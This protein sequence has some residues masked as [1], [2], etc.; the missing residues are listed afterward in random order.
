MFVLILTF[1]LALPVRAQEITP[2]VVDSTIPVDA[3][4]R[5]AVD[6]W[7]ATSAPVPYPYY[8][9]T[10]VDPNIDTFVSLVAVDIANPTDAWNATEDNTVVWRGSVIVRA[11]NS[12]ELFLP[13][14]PAEIG[15]T[16]RLAI[17]KFPLPKPDAGGGSY[18]SFPW[19]AGKAMMYGQNGVHD[20]GGIRVEFVAVDFVGGDDMG[21]GVAGPQV[22][23]SLGGTVE[24][25]CTGASSTAIQIYSPGTTD[26]LFY[27]NLV[28]NANLTGA[29]TFTKGE[30]IG[31]LK[32]GSFTDDCGKATQSDNR[33]NL[34][35]EVIPSTADTFRMENCVLSTVTGKWTC[36]TTAVSPGQ[37]LRGST[38][39]CALDDC[40]SAVAQAS[41][42]D[43]FLGGVISI[44]EKTIIASLPEH[45]AMQFT[46]VIYNTVKLMLRIAWV[47]VYSNI[48]L[49]HLM[50]ALFVGLGIR[51]AFSVAEF[52][53]F[54][55]K[56]WK[57]LVPIIGS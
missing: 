47:M 39:G 41:L 38:A 26:H 44:Y 12:V 34:H 24:W 30:M 55:L 2:S 6:A 17:P 57:S 29:H 8:A 25:V 20:S 18:I 16:P 33:Y 19:T 36:G 15:L 32:Y 7:L 51:T 11:D 1:V 3:G 28:D 48:N 37:F 5:S 14:T 53:V 23:A 50:S 56:A 49:G 4:I 42:W 46:Y 21:P 9:I 52:I 13:H 22:Y 35:M 45:S 31:V 27:A 40:G 54:L 10:Y 43:G